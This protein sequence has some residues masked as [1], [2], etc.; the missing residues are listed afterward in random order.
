MT[1]RSIGLCLAL[2]VPPTAA[3]A[4]PLSGSW[5]L[6]RERSHYGGGAEVRR[7]EFFTC[8]SDGELP[9]CTI[10]SV[11]ADG[12]KMV[13]S[14]TAAYDGR[15]H[16]VLGIPDVD[17]VTLRKRDEFVADASFGFKG[18]PVFGYR[19]FRSDD[20]RFLTVVSVDPTSGVVLNSVVAYDRR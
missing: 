5:T 12:R 18:R 3:M 19:V 1:P 8:S 15:P 6:D 17:E 13:G 10:T 4:D 9:K 7:E 16:P 11:R 20:G 2:L 14:F